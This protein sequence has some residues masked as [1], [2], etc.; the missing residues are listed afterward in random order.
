MTFFLFLGGF[1]GF[2]LW[3]LFSWVF[4]ERL[5]HKAGDAFGGGAEDVVKWIA[6]L[7]LAWAVP[8]SI[9]ATLLSLRHT[10]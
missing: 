6:W 3:M 5:S 2:I 9:G 8:C 1:T 4:S 10:P 7:F